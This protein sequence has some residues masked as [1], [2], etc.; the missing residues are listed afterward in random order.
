MWYRK[1]SNSKPGF[2][3]LLLIIS[4]CT[5]EEYSYRIEEPVVNQ[6][7]VVIDKKGESFIRQEFWP[8]IPGKQM[9][10]DRIQAEKL[11]RLMVSKLDEGIFP[12]AISTA[13][14]ENILTAT[15]GIPD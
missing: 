1:I 9:F 15:Q 7:V 11:A 2:L 5:A 10:T 14:V 12:P 4:G 3:I 13:E 6:Y 8:S